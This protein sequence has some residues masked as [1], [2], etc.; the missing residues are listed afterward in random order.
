MNTHQQYFAKI[1]SFCDRAASVAHLNKM[2]SQIRKDLALEK[3]KDWVRV[4]RASIELIQS[5]I[6]YRNSL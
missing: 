1:E 3:D 6:D 5:E 2:A 4:Y